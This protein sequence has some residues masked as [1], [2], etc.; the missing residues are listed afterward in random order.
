MRYLGNKTSLLDFLD[1][2]IKSFIGN[3]FSKFNH[4]YDLFSGTG[5][6]SNHFKQYISIV[7]NDFLL[8]SYYVTYAKLLN[9]Y[10]SDLEKYI[11]YLNES[12]VLGDITKHYSEG[13]KRLYFS[14]ENGMKIDYIRNF[15]K[16]STINKDLHHYLMYC[17]IHS[18]HKVSN[19][20]GVYG[21]YLKTL[22]NHNTLLVEKLPISPSK[23][24]HYCHNNDASSLINPSLL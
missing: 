9:N 20:T 16:N 23:F 6:V 15:L 3:D 8:S 11:H 17:F 21:A 4:F 14:K 12:C 22:Q 5:S 7:S 1:T 2:H 10:P 24:T 13:S 19:T 18:I